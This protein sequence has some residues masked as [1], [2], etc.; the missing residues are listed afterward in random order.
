MI[1]GKSKVRRVGRYSRMV[2]IPRI[3][4]EDSFNNFV[5]DEEVLIRLEKKRIIIT[6]SDNKGE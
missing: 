1:D 6:K 4:W 5:D 2:V 3:V